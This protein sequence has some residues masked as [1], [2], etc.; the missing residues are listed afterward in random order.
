MGE[1]SNVARLREGYG[2]F[3]NGDFDTVRAFIAPDAVW[4]VPGSNPLSGDYKGHDEIFGLFSQ[5]VQKTG[6]TL[7]SEIHDV[8]ANDEHGTVLVRFSA[9]REDGRRLDQHE[10]HVVHLKDGQVVEWWSFEEDVAA[11]DAFFS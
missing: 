10:V 6:G 5:L 9:Q 1:H 8:L 7:K 4:H 3:D 2:A 11:A